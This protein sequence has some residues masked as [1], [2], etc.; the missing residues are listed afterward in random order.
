[1]STGTGGFEAAT[2][3][4]LGAVH[5]DATL[6]PV[7]VDND[8]DLDVVIATHPAMLY[9]YSISVLLNQ[10]DGTLGTSIVSPLA[11]GYSFASLA[12]ADINGDGNVDAAFADADHVP[13]VASAREPGNSRHR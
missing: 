2:S 11:N 13:L 9:D 6:A 10:G 12:I 4:P 8:D 3:Y 7:D 5:E 1:M